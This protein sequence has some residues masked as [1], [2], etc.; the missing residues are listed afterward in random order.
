MEYNFIK[1]GDEFLIYIYLVI[2]G[3]YVYLKISEWCY[4]VGIC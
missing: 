4:S 3:N 2:C 1:I